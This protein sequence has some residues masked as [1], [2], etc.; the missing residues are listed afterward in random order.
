VLRGLGRGRG[1]AWS[2]EPAPVTALSLLHQALT[3]ALS[4][5]TA[6]LS[7]LT[8]IPS[9]GCTVCGTAMTPDLV[10]NEWHCSGC[11][12]TFPRVVVG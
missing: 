12:T 4:Q 9:P 10:R 2:A 3:N 1:F 5:V 6:Q 7:T 8:A 11:G